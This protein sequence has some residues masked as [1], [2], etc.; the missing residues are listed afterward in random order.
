[1]FVFIINSCMEWV[2]WFLL[3]QPPPVWR[4]NIERGLLTHSINSSSHLKH[5]LFFSIFLLRKTS[6]G[7]KFSSEQKR[8]RPLLFYLSFLTN[9]AT[10]NHLDPWSFYFS[11]LSLFLPKTK[12]KKERGGY[13]SNPPPTYC[14]CLFLFPLTNCLHPL[15]V[16]DTRS[17]KKATR[18]LPE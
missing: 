16:P 1:M 14:W 15:R 18:K 8:Q 13:W 6:H 2:G 11:S 10:K 5:S 17:E 3:K 4:T 12:K 7:G 9:K